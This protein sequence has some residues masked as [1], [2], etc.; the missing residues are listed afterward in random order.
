MY[1]DT[2]THTS[3]V[4]HSRQIV[5]LQ[6]IYC[7]HRSRSM[8]CNLVM[9]TH[10]KCVYIIQLL[11]IFMS[12]SSGSAHFKRLCKCFHHTFSHCCSTER[13][14]TEPVVTANTAAK[15]RGSLMCDFTCD[16]QRGARG[17]HG[18]GLT[19][20]FSRHCHAG[21]QGSQH[22]LTNVTIDL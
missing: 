2:L 18:D 3:R 15:A 11:C 7:S 4:K 13:L 14:K 22:H 17:R 12:I 21:A 1:T 16:K 8:G 9:K 5:P 10:T 19:N 6:L 20:P